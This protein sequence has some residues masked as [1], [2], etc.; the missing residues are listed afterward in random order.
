MTQGLSTHTDEQTNTQI[1][2]ALIFGD[3]KNYFKY[4]PRNW[5]L[6]SQY[7]LL[8]EGGTEGV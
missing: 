7:Y 2:Q 6:G 8:I 4:D 5:T 3:P 1:G